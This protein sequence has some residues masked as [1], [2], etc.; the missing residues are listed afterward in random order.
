MYTVSTIVTG[1]APLIQHKFP[2]PEFEQLTKGGNRS[3]G[4]K[5]YTNEW[6]E[7]LYFDADGQIYQP[8]VHFEAAMTKAAV[9]YKVT[10]KRGKTYKDLVSSSVVVDPERIPHVGHTYTPELMLDLDADK[11]LY[12]DMRPVIVQRA[13]VVR[14]RPV[15]KEGWE[16]SFEIQVLDDEIQ[17][18]LLQ[19]I[20][21]LAGKSVGIGDYRPKFGRFQVT[22]FEVHK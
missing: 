3:T 6:R 2:M 20:L 9:S 11:P 17:P 10:G 4:A 18:S 12:L 7:Y 22:R 15:F 5:D 19:D 13:R 14:I 21:A 16:L 8:S 1:I